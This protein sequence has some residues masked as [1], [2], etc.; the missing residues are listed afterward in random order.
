[1]LGIRDRV[2]DQFGGRTGNPE[3]YSDTLYYATYGVGD[4]L[5]ACADGSG[6]WIM[7]SNGTCGGMTGGG[8]NNRDGFGT[9]PNNG[10]YY[11][12]QFSSH[13]EVQFGGLAQIPSKDTVAV[14]SMDSTALNEGTISVWNHDSGLRTSSARLYLT[15]GFGISTGGGVFGK[16]NGLGDLE[17]LC[18]AA[19]T[20]I[21]NRVWDDY[22][23][24]GVQDAGEPGMNGLTVTL[25]TPTGNS[26]TVTSGNGNYTFTVDV[27]T[28]YTITVATAR[29]LHADCA[30]HGCRRRPQ[31]YQ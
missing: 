13:S 9:S 11:L 27:Y 29:G 12:D 20:E 22:D 19:P 1:M 14:T 15:T 31:L 23:G 7:E 10:E 24:N 26:T 28:P 16:A 2:A 21:G 8:A 4:L 3:N 25:E 17:A 5:R 30:Q 18:A 6:G